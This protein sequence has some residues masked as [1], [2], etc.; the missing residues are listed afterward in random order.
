MRENWMQWTKQW[1]LDATKINKIL[2]PEAQFAYNT[3]QFSLIY[4]IHVSIA[5]LCMKLCA[6]EQFIWNRRA[7]DRSRQ[8]E[9]CHWIYQFGY[10]SMTIPWPWKIQAKFIRTVHKSISKHTSTNMKIETNYGT[11][12]KAAMLAHLS[13]CGAG[14][15]QRILA[16]L[17]PQPVSSG[18]H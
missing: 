2:R 14:R 13:S 5:L 3:V 4:Y 9:S 1:L 11:C 7:D 10:L 17:I 16:V 6:Q 12:T 18:R 8:Q 15:D